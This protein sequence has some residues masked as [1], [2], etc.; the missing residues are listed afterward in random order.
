MTPRQLELYTFICAFFKETG[1]GPSFEEMGMAIRAESKSS[2]SR[3]V[4]GLEAAGWITRLR[5]RA[6]SIIPKYA[7]PSQGQIRDV[8]S[9][10][11]Y[12]GSVLAE[13]D[14][15]TLPAPETVERLRQVV[16]MLGGQ[17]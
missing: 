10:T 9:A 7:A 17:A 16:P 4:E 5:H 3:L 12:M 15:G 13:Y 8:I 1:Y 2:V 14:A 6:R 11:R